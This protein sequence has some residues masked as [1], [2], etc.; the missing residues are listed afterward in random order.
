MWPENVCALSKGASG[1]ISFRAPFVRRRRFFALQKK[2]SGLLALIA[3]A[4]GW[5]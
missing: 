5:G 1:S 4:S 2:P 3:D